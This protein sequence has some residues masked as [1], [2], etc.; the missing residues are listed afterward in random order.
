MSVEVIYQDKAVVLRRGLDERGWFY[1]EETYY[2]LPRY[3]NHVRYR[4]SL[5]PTAKTCT[6]LKVWQGWA[7]GEGG[8]TGSAF[9]T[10]HLD[11]DEGSALRRR[12][13]ELKT[14]DEFHDVWA[15]LWWRE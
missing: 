10:I 8:L 3:M 7:M 4:I 12:L 15:D 13:R 1:V 9:M 5:S 14:L 11:E 2:P 6:L